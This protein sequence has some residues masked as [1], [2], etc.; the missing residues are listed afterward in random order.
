[1][2]TFPTPI[3]RTAFSYDPT[4]PVPP[5]GSDDCGSLYPCGSAPVPSAPPTP[6]IYAN[7]W[8]APDPWI[9]GPPLPGTDPTLFG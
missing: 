6:P 1:M 8:L 4:P 7:P 2:Q 3:L 9:S 5:V